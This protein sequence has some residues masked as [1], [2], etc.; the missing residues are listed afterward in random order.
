MKKQSATENT[1]T[2]IED[3]TLSSA[4]FSPKSD[5]RSDNVK[6]NNTSK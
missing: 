2:I 5:L 6:V 3:G 1:R 4:G